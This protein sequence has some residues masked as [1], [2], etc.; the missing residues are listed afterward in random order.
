MPLKPYDPKISP[1]ESLMK[2]YGVPFTREN[3]LE[4]AGYDSAPTA[5]QEQQIPVRFRKPDEDPK[6]IKNPENGE[7]K[8]PARA[9]KPDWE[10]L[11]KTVKR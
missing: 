1:T 7:A 11:M 6:T 10:S 9:A 3:Y 2:H 8:K 5:E 4:L